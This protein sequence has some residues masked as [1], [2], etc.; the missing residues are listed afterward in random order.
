MA[1]VLEDSVPYITASHLAMPLRPS[2]GA[3]YAHIPRGDYSGDA[4]SRQSFFADY[5]SRPSLMFLRLPHN[6]PLQSELLSTITCFA[7]KGKWIL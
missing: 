6:D 3:I 5:H 7:A 4:S 1:H 2:I